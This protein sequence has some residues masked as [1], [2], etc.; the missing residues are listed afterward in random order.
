MKY[1]TVLRHAKSSWNHP[2]ISDHDRPLNDRGLRA[3][4]AVADFLHRTYYGGAE[5][6]QLLPNPSLILTSTAKRAYTTA[7][8]LQAGLATSQPP[9][10]TTQK[11]YMA[12]PETLLTHARDLDDTHEHAVLVGH[13][14]GIQEF[15]QR[16]LSRASVPRVPTCTVVIMGL[17]HEHW[18]LLDWGE[19]QLIG[20]ITPR[21]LERRFPERYPGI[22]RGIDEVD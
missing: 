21:S 17:P 13:N 9:L 2:G 16:L 12:S 20:Y 5:T 3:A 7:H 18:G 4:P 19:A 22:T 6:V 15:C 10:Q 14:P 1:L 8:L 11:L